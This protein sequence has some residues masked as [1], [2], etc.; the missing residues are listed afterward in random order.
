MTK[1]SLQGF[2]TLPYFSTF[3]GCLYRDQSEL[4]SNV[5]DPFSWDVLQGANID[6]VE[7]FG[8]SY[9]F[10]FNSWSYFS[11]LVNVVNLVALVSAK[12]AFKRK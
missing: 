12:F 8:L 9:L 2:E 6:N 1:E 7:K 10:F 3:L 11:F 4:S 5:E